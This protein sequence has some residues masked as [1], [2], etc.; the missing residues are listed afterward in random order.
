MKQFWRNI[1]FADRPAQ[2][3]FFSLWLLMLGSYILFSLLLLVIAGDWS[4]L[5]LKCDCLFYL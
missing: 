4:Q 5:S 1:F 3:A 2:G